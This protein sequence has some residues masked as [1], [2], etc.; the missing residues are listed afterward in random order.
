MPCTYYT[1][2]EHASIAANES[3]QAQD[4]ITQLMRELDLATRVACTASKLLLK[5]KVKFRNPE[6][7]EWIKSHERKDREKK[8]VL[9]YKV[10]KH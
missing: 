4:K 2:E 7:S 6:L 5:H 8:I 3:R 10:D 9:I 1:A